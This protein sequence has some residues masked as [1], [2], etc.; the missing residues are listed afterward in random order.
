MKRTSRGNISKRITFHCYH[1]HCLRLGRRPQRQFHQSTLKH[2]RLSPAKTT[3]KFYL[4]IKILSRNW[5]KIFDELA[6]FIWFDE[7]ALQRRR[8]GYEFS[9]NVVLFF[10]FS[11][12]YLFNIYYR[13]LLKNFS[14][15]TLNHRRNARASNWAKFFAWNPQDELRWWFLEIFNEIQSNKQKFV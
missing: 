4:C 15:K 6:K 5:Q 14:I 7:N 8:R 10:S 2:A 1:L 12:E 3:P 13:L 9:S 11:V